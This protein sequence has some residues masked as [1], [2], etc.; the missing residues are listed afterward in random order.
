MSLAVNDWL[1]GHALFRGVPL[2]TT[3][4]IHRTRLL[5][6]GETV[7]WDVYMDSMAAIGGIV[8]WM[9]TEGV[10]PALCSGCPL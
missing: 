8:P 10:S 2:C 7:A 5:C 4:L 3:R 9:L 1:H 6:R